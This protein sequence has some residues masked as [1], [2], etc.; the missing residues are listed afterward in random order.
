MVFNNSLKTE[1]GIKFPQSKIESFYNDNNIVGKK[2][3]S[4]YT[5]M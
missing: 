3:I 1:S 2:I 4:A 5:A